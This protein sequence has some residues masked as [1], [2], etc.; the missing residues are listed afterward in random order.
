MLDKAV[1]IPRPIFPM[2]ISVFCAGWRATP[3]STRAHCGAHSLGVIIPRRPQLLERLES[4]SVG[5]LSPEERF[6]G[7]TERGRAGSCGSLVRHEMVLEC[8]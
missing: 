6:Q 7:V 2:N 4:D 3:I 8:L 5:S 1:R